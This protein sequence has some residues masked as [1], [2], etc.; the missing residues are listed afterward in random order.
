MGSRAPKTRTRTP[1]EST[2]QVEIQDYRY[3]EKRKN[4]PS[5][6]L[7]TYNFKEVKKVT[8]SYD[9]HLDPQLLWAGKPST[10]LSRS[11][12]FPCT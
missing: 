12:P 10:P 11:T 4:N 1:R 8:Y 9:P 2:H 5:A 3:K 6:G 7:A